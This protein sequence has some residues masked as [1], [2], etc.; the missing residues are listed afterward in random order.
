MDAIEIRTVIIDGKMYLP[1]DN[2]YILSEITRGL[3]LL[4]KNR[5]SARSSY[6]KKVQAVS[7]NKISLPDINI[8]S[9]S[10]DSSPDSVITHAGET[11]LP[12]C[13]KL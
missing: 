3:K 8:I 6:Q 9:D 2:K 4:Q 7:R 11:V 1:I 12:E 13:F 10:S 5:A